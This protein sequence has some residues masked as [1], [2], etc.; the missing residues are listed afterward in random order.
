M[1]R[2]GSHVPDAW[3]EDGLAERIRLLRSF[4]RRLACRS[5]RRHLQGKQ[6]RAFRL[7][8]L[9]PECLMEEWVEVQEREAKLCLSAQ[10]APVISW[11]FSCD[12]GFRI[13]GGSLG[14]W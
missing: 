2:G 6:G 9:L 12:F 8:G 3:C 13:D 14:Y 4:R 7:I 10:K 1:L 5:L 11:S